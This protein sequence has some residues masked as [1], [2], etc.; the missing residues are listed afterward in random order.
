MTAKRTVI[1]IILSSPS[2]SSQIVSSFV[3]KV[4][5]FFFLQTNFKRGRYSPRDTLF[6]KTFDTFLLSIT[7]CLYLLCGNLSCWSVFFFHF[8]LL[9]G[10][11]LSVFVRCH[12]S[13][14]LLPRLSFANRKKKRKNFCL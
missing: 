4:F 6:S 1:E 7:L 14:I 12:C 8:I 5:A 10:K 11:S 9:Q 2:S 13:W 3:A